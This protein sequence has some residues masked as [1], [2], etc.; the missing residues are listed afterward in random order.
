[1]FIGEGIPSGVIVT[2]LNNNAIAYAGVGG[3][4]YTPELTSA[5]SIIPINWRIVF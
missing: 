5:R 1:M 2:I 3:G 4:V